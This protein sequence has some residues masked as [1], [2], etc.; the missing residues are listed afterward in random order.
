MPVAGVRPAVCQ[1][2]R[3]WY[4]IWAVHGNMTVIIA[5]IA[6]YVGA[7]ACHMTNFLTLKAPVII[8]GNAVD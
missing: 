7:I 5:I 8:T 2:T 6:P 3:W 1:C 4:F